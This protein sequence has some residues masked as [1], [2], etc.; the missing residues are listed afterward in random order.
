MARI[1]IVMPQ[2]GESITN[3]TITKWRKQ[4]GDKVEL[5]EILFEISTDK[6]ES[7]IPSPVEGRLVNHLFKEGDTVDVGLVLAQIED[8]S[9]VS[10]ETEQ[11]IQKTSSPSDSSTDRSVS[12]QSPPPSEKSQRRF[13]TPLVK[14]MAE[15]EGISLDQLASIQGSGV[16]GRVNRKDLENFLKQTSPPQSSPSSTPSAPSVPSAIQMSSGDD[17]QIV[18]MDNMRKTIAK[19]MVLSK[20]ISPHVNSMSEVDMTHLVV[21]REKIKDEFLKREGFKITYTPFIIYALV[22]ALKEFPFVNASIDGDNILVRKQINIGCAV[23]VP[24]NGL[25][26]PVIK[27]ADSLNLAGMARTVNVLAQKAREKKLSLD[28]LSGGTFTF[29]NVGSFGTLMATPVIVQPQVGIYASGFIQKRV[30]AMKDNSM[31]IRSMMYGTHA[32][33]HRLIDGEMGGLFLE[34]I[35]RHLIQMRPEELL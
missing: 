5:D 6:V 9:S 23:A 14:A 27:N 24:G 21:F 8:D 25:I 34:S 3:G 30:V 29:S 2:M 35:H 15:K 16:A 28:E 33:D 11:P 7:E 17:V 10:L 4:P 18:P 32:Y 12:D 19:N 1:D 26:V 31:A 22:Q 13:Y 20:Q